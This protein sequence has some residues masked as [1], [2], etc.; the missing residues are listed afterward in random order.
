MKQWRKKKVKWKRRITISF[1]L[2]WTCVI[3]SLLRNLLC[4]FTRNR[5]NLKF[6]LKVKVNRC[7]LIFQ[8]SKMKATNPRQISIEFLALSQRKFNYSNGAERKSFFFV[9]L[10]KK[11]TSMA[12]KATKPFSANTLKNIKNSSKGWTPDARS[13]FYCI[14]TLKMQ[15][16]TPEF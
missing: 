7:L 11:K 8:E 2:K 9:W 15:S 13:H 5:R 14:G 1:G 4:I 10:Q 16:A 3:P 12:I 6:K